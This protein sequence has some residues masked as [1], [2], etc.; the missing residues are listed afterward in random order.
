[1][2]LPVTS[3]LAGFLA[4]WFIVLSMRVI[5][6]RRRDRVSLGDGGNDTL[7]RRIRAH[8]NFAEY[9][10][11]GILLCGLCE[12]QGAPLWLTVTGAAMVGAGRLGHGYALSFTTGS[13]IGRTGGMV[14]TFCGIALLA[15][16]AMASALW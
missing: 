9:A 8:G 16:V 4:L 12:V 15:V 5:A 1:M 2:Q 3:I 6:I 7:N 13:M 11:L 14:A 10:P